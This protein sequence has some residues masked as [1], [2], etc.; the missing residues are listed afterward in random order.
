M[1]TLRQIYDDEV[2]RLRNEAGYVEAPTYQ[3]LDLRALLAGGL[4][5]HEWIV[6]DVWPEGRSIHIHAQR[7]AGKSL[8]MLWMAAHVAMGR[9]PFTRQIIRPR[10]TGSWDQE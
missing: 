5:E 8:V 4:K 9:D 6:E 2:S 3:P 10:R 1:V 7:K